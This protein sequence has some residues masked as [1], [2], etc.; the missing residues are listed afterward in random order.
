MGARRL[1]FAG[2]IEALKLWDATV[3]P[4]RPKNESD[5]GLT[6]SVSEG[7]AAAVTLRVTG[8]VTGLPLMLTPDPDASETWREP[9]YVPAVMPV[10]F[11]NTGN[12]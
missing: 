1:E 3:L 10:G 11:T 8:M 7:G 6:E 9:E 5:V 2:R 4:T 12:G